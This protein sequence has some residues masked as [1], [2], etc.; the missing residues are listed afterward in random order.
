MTDLEPHFFCVF[1]KETSKTLEDQLKEKEILSQLLEVVNQR[2]A[3]IEMQEKK[4]LSELY[5]HAPAFGDLG[6]I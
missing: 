5:E 2:S 4:R 6:K 1:F 3:L